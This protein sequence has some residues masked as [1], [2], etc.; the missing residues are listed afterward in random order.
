MKSANIAEF[1]DHLGKYLTIVEQGGE[2]QL[3]KRNIPMAMII[4]V[5]TKAT[6][7]K[8]KLGCGG[9]SVVISTD[10]TEPIFLPDDWSMM[11]SNHLVK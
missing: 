3:C 2:V 6:I 5:K 11:K 7:N 8:T 10:L 1:K 9:G 4:P